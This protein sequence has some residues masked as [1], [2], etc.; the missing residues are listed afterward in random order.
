MAEADE[1]LRTVTSAVAKVDIQSLQSA[2]VWLVQ[3]HEV[4]KN[5]LAVAAEERAAL[6]IR[7]E[8]LERAA[9]DA[10]TK[11]AEALSSLG[12]RL[13]SA[14]TQLDT[15][16]ASADELSQLVEQGRVIDQQLLDGVEALEEK[17]GQTATQLAEARAECEQLRAAD[18]AAAAALAAASEEARAGTAAVRTAVEGLRERLPELET[19]VQTTAQKL[20]A[21]ANALDVRFIEAEQA[22]DAKLHAELSKLLSR[23]T[24]A[25]ERMG[26]TQP[27]AEGKTQPSAEGKTQLAEERRAPRAPAAE[28]FAVAPSQSVAAAIEEGD[29]HSSF[30]GRLTHVE[31]LLDALQTDLEGVHSQVGKHRAEIASTSD[32]VG[33][34]KAVL[35]RLAVQGDVGGGAKPPAAAAPPPSSAPAPVAAPAAN[36]LLPRALEMSVSSSSGG[37]GVCKGGGGGGGGGG[38]RL[39]DSTLAEVL[40]QLNGQL[41]GQLD[42]LR[43]RL[44]LCEA[45]LSIGAEDRGEA[46]DGSG[47]LAPAVMEAIGVQLG[48]IVRA[49]KQKADAGEVKRVE[50]LVLAA[51]GDDGGG[52]KRSGS[53]GSGLGGG[54]GGGGGMGMV[55]ALSQL[56][57]QDARLSAME[58]SVGD[59]EALAERVNAKLQASE[60]HNAATMRQQ[61]ASQQRLQALVE[62]GGLAAA[63]AQAA[64]RAVAA[65]LELLALATC[66]LAEGG[67]WGVRANPNQPDELY[68]ESPAYIAAAEAFEPHLG[69]ATEASGPALAHVAELLTRHE[70]QCKADLSALGR[71]GALVHSAPNA[72]AAAAAS[73]SEPALE[74]GMSA[75]AGVAGYHPPTSGGNLAGWRRPPRGKPDVR[76]NLGFVIPSVPPVPG[77]RTLARPAS[78]GTLSTAARP[79][80]GASGTAS[81][82]LTGA[83]AESL[84]A[85]LTMVERSMSPGSALE[86]RLAAMER[87]NRTNAKTRQMETWGKLWAAINRL[88]VRINMVEQHA[89]SSGTRS[90]AAQRLSDVLGTDGGVMSGGAS[91]PPPSQGREDGVRSAHAAAFE[92]AAFSVPARLLSDGGLPMP[93]EDLAPMMRQSP[94]GLWPGHTS[95]RSQRYAPC[96]SV[97]ATE[98]LLAAIPGLLD[99]G[100]SMS[101]SPKPGSLLPSRASSMQPSRSSTSRPASACVRDGK[102]RP[103][104]ATSTGGAQGGV[105]ESRPSS[106]IRR[107]TAT[108][109]SITPLDGGGG[110]IGAN[111]DFHLGPVAPW[112]GH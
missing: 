3:Q 90:A 11:Q 49:L 21:T 47:S 71:L 82:A 15:V 44:S 53:I 107:T 110:P 7:V 108:A 61:R 2:L 24:A 86:L 30:S 77:A 101:S 28:V 75:P 68:A 92:A 76:G 85:R 81:G 4:N 36:S 51:L 56:A 13:D 25:E 94:E 79:G 35:N 93:G 55:N 29:K 111:A 16:T 65:P 38:G 66:R 45:A 112:P 5:N 72:A 69:E 37:G 26:K 48:P 105:A 32:S 63:A 103:P 12:A 98:A 43:R 97:N 88:A 87:M 104:S 99:D 33:E 22:A 95:P 60:R 34:L 1:V 6:R 64:R 106:A 39:D 83:A 41:N 8:K 100:T 74:V 89:I 58:A 102:M 20:D 14:Q 17:A 42:E 18:A 23:L 40:G 91:P 54:S 73:P 10:A 67:R 31:W 59:V 109:P 19:L 78:A 52:L 27:S 84:E 96:G 46:A 50:A 62:G 80:G 9:Q 57:A 70:I